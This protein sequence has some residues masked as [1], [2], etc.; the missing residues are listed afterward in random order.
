MPE[1]NPRREV[2][3]P[4]R[5]EVGERDLE[6]LHVGLYHKHLPVLESLG[7]VDWDR[8]AHTVS[9]GSDFGEIR[10]KLELLD[11]HRGRLSDGW[12]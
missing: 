12:V 4:E 11:E 10:P 8:V 1:H 3:V 9:K 2:P 7:L 6:A 5:I